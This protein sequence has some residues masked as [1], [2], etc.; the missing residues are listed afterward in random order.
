MNYFSLLSLCKSYLLLFL[1]FII[2]IGTLILCC[3]T[4]DLGI[5][6]RPTV[7]HIFGVLLYLTLLC[8]KLATSVELFYLITVLCSS[9]IPDFIAY[10]FTTPVNKIKNTTQKRDAQQNFQKKHQHNT[11]DGG[12]AMGEEM[13]HVQMSRR[14][15]HIGEESK[16]QQWLWGRGQSILVQHFIART[17][18]M[19]GK[20]SL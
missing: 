9:N 4:T 16:Q 13:R 5:F 3:T 14:G 6:G 2:A 15:K 7:L 10:Q 20:Q 17:S 19:G 12:Q 1:T 18:S 8:V 11:D